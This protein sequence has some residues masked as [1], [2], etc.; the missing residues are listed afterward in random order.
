MRERAEGEGP[1]M[2]TALPLTLQSPDT[3]R[4]KSPA[5]SPADRPR[6]SPPASTRCRSPPPPDRHTTMSRSR[7]TSQTAPGS[8]R[9]ASRSVLIQPSRPCTCLL[10]YRANTAL[11]PRDTSGA[12]PACRCLVPPAPLPAPAPRSWHS[13]AHDPCRRL[14][15]HGL[16]ARDPVPHRLQVGVRRRHHRRTASRSG[17]AIPSC[18]AASRPAAAFARSQ[19]VS[20]SLARFRRSTPRPRQR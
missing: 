13:V 4:S 12:T 15:V 8:R 17:M 1:V 14:Q 3:L 11:T 7:Q 19:I 10:R 5:R 9:S 20:A 18:T 16:R 2:R 6:Q